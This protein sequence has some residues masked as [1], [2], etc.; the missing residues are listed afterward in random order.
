MI[1]SGDWTAW[2]NHE[3]SYAYYC[4]RKCTQGL[5]R[6]FFHAIRSEAPL[7]ITSLRD[8]AHDLFKKI[9]DMSR[10]CYD[11][12]WPLEKCREVGA[13]LLDWVESHHLYRR[14][15][16]LCRRST[17]MWIIVSAWNTVKQWE[18]DPCSMER[19]EMVPSAGTLM[20][21]MGSFQVLT[22]VDECTFDYYPFQIDWGERFPDVPIGTASP[23]ASEE[24]SDEYDR[25][26]FEA[27]MAAKQARQTELLEKHHL[28][29][30]PRKRETDHFKWLVHYVVHQRSSEEIK[31]LFKEEHAVTVKRGINEAAKLLVGP[32]WRLWRPQGR[33]GRPRRS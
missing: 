30:A 26:R 2:P 16:E 25:E 1:P 4:S 11:S 5:Q 33:A 21:D 13:A 10:Y 9:P 23:F 27:A 20:S 12:P 18:A 22:G 32:N 29:A 6:M 28:I 8:V 15:P 17:A 19:L 3:I 24:D 7:V 14:D 31:N